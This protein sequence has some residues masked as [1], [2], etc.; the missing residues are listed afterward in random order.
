MDR[1]MMMEEF[2]HRQRTSDPEILLSERRFYKNNAPDASLWTDATLAP[3]PAA[4]GTLFEW[5]KRRADGVRAGMAAA[6]AAAAAL[7]VGSTAL[8]RTTGPAPATGR[9]RG[10]GTGRGGG[11]RPRNPDPNHR[12]REIQIVTQFFDEHPFLWEK[13]RL[14][15]PHRGFLITRL[16]SELGSSHYE[17]PAGLTP[18]QQKYRNQQLTNLVNLARQARRGASG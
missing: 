1:V 10:R 9:G 6:A 2:R 15:H 17:V 13:K 5:L 14:D 12:S 7:A 8:A 16:T 4:A 18:G 11:R 3:P